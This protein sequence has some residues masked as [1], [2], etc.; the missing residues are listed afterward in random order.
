MPKIAPTT[1]PAMAA[2]LKVAVLEAFESWLIDELVGVFVFGAVVVV[3]VVKGVVSL[4]G[5][6]D[7]KRYTRIFQDDLDD[8]ES[9]YIDT[10]F[11]ATL[12]AESDDDDDEIGDIGQDK[13]FRK[14]AE[15]EIEEAGGLWKWT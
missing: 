4:G 15:K 10:E 7:G 6:G 8:L 11:S 1:I 2:P 12:G 13:F 5:C 9:I 3:V 14:L